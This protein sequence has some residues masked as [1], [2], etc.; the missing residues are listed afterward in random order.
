MHDD[1]TRKR[2]AATAPGLGKPN[3]GSAQAEV[4]ESVIT[5]HLEGFSICLDDLDEVDGFPR[6]DRFDAALCVMMD[7][8]AGE[9][10]IQA[11]DHNPF[12]QSLYGVRS[13]A[14]NTR[15]VGRGFRIVRSYPQTPESD[16]LHERI[17][18]A[19][20]AAAQARRDRYGKR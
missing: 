13:M 18:R 2:T 3:E 12:D 7:S 5:E 15:D 6:G 11:V 8:H 17:E 9:P 14:G 4:T 20:E 1:T 16:A 19:Y 10:E